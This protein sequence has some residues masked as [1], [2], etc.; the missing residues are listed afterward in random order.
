MALL[1]AT[2][3]VN[4]TA[5]EEIARRFQAMPT[6]SVSARRC[7]RPVCLALALYLLGPAGG[8]GAE[9]QVVPEEDDVKAAFLYNFA[10]F[11]QWPP[12]THRSSDI[13][14]G[15]LGSP[16]MLEVL[17]LIARGSRINGSAVVA[18][19]FGA[20]D[21]PRA[22]HIVFVR[23]EGTWRAREIL[24]RVRHAGVLTVGE[25]PQFL[26]DGGLIRFYVRDRRVRFEMDPVGAQRDGLRISS[27]LLSLAAR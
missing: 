7:P 21:D 4:R 16:R 24:Q 14:I 13:V 1:T 11:V 10:K 25:A 20:D 23:E 19:P 27:H 6:T 18:R 5:F 15:V 26:A 8:T 2:L 12:S 3:P 22:Y 17:E 9:A